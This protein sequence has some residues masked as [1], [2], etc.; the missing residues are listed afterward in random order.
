MGKKALLVID[1]QKSLVEDKP[2]DI[3]NVVSNIQK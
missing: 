3:D 2:F 1:M